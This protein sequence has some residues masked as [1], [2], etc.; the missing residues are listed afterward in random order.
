MHPHREQML[1]LTSE[2]RAAWL[3]F[4]DVHNR[5]VK[6][7]DLDLEREHRLSLSSYDVLAVLSLAPG[8]RM[9][10]SELADTVF[11]TRAGI[12]RLVQRLER[13]GL[14]ERCRCE[15]D[16]RQV[17]AHITEHGLQR[18]GEAAETHFRGVRSRFLDHL[19]P[20]QKH[21]LARA[22]TQMLGEQP[23]FVDLEAI[24]HQTSTH[25]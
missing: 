20:N 17:F 10:M 23:P 12:T 5:V 16:A 2:E 13:D 19:S 4:L 22:W 24:E 18:L 3:G 1:K 14:V 9:R 15:E 21:E 7:L 11:I 25:P 8:G 6:Q